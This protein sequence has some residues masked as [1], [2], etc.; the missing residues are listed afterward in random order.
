G[1]EAAFGGLVGPRGRVPLGAPGVLGLHPMA[2]SD[3][4]G[5][6]GSGVALELDR[7]RAGGAGGLD[8]LV[9]ELHVAVVVDPRLRDHVTRLAAPHLAAVDGEGGFHRA[10]PTM[11]ASRATERRLA[12]LWRRWALMR[13]RSRS[14]SRSAMASRVVTSRPGRCR[15][16]KI[17]CR[18]ATSSASSTVSRYSGRYRPSGSAPA[19]IRNSSGCSLMYRVVSSERWRVSPFCQER[20]RAARE[21]TSLRMPMSSASPGT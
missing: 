15:R 9:A 20:S 13:A 3:A 6:L 7:V 1:L 18:R 14:R 2:R 17:S 10:F 8:E 12:A 21:T 16:A 19:T 11:P 5:D 4:G